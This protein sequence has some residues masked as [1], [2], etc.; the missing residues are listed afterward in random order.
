M[1]VL[2]HIRAK[3]WSRKAGPLKLITALQGFVTFTVPALDA[4]SQHSL[5]LCFQ[6]EKFPTLK[7]D[8]I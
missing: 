2:P 1:L 5:V 4:Y 8:E 6:L 7:G 3:T